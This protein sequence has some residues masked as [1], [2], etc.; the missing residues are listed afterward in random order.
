MGCSC[1]ANVDRVFSDRTA[2]RELR[3]YRKKGPERA[4]RSLLQA[5]ESA[6]V[7]GATVL[8]IGGG[9]GVIQHELLA[10]GAVSAVSVDASRNYAAVLREEAERCSLGDRIVS[11][12]GDFVDVADSLD[13]AEIV[14]M[15]KVICCYPDME[16]LVALAAQRSTRLLGLVFPRDTLVVRLGG[17]LLNGVLWLT[18]NS[19]RWIVHNPAAVDRT[20]RR[21]GFEPCF[22]NDARGLTPWQ[23]VVY[24]R[25]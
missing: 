7:E 19:L 8:D 2:R 11:I 15:D 3:R 18:R 6:G 25:S 20:I 1:C 24:R 17:S 16:A 23:V 5:L 10:H 13:P 4:T 21:E 22:T 9:I 12:D 14:T